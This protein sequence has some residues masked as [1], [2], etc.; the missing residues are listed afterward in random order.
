VSDQPIEQ[1]QE[2]LMCGGKI[3]LFQNQVNTKGRNEIKKRQ[4]F[5]LFSIFNLFFEKIIFH[6]KRNQGRIEV[7]EATSMSTG[8]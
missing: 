4:T 7:G 6:G 2:S 5:N 8:F 1:A 3:L